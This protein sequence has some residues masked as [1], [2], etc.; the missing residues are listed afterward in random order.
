MIQ[1]KSKELESIADPPVGELTNQAN[2][3]VAD[4]KSLMINFKEF[5]NT[6]NRVDISYDNGMFSYEFQEIKA[7]V[8]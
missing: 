1:I 5:I 2:Q 6:F 8:N 4:K 3:T 7:T